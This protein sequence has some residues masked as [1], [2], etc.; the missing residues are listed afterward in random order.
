MTERT[1][2]HP[3][4]GRL[5]SLRDRG[6]RSGRA[7][8]LRSVR[9]ALVS[10]AGLIGRPVSNQAGDEV[11]RVVDVVVNFSPDTELE[12]Y[13]PATGLIIRVGR[14]RSWVP[15]SQIAHVA[16]GEV[17]LASARVDLREF[18]PRDGEMQ[19]AASVLDHQLIDV[20]GRRVIRAADLVL[21]QLRGE[22]RLVG[23][24]VST[25]SLLRRLGPARL[26]VRPTPERVIDWAAIQPLAD[27]DRIGGVRLRTSGRA[28]SALRPGELAD[29]LEE[30]GRSERQHLL[31][32]LDPEAAADAV[33][34]MHDDDVHRLLRD[35]PPETAA[36]LL[37]QMEPDEA[38]DAL[39][40]M[41]A[42]ERAR[43]LDAMP[44]DVS[45]RLARLLGYDE[46]RAGGV[47]T[48]TL[49]QCAEHDTVAQVTERLRDLAAHAVDLSAIVVVDPQ[50]RLLDDV[51]VL[52]L[53][54]ADRDRRLSELIGPPWPVTV[55]PDTPVSEVAVALIA[56]RSASILVV[57]EDGRPLGRI[58]A[59]DIVDAL[60]SDKTRFQLFRHAPA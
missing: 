14:R 50:G 31:D 27:A 16:H 9:E 39:R 35:A 56:N 54:L 36:E 32:T 42:A 21:A 18:E 19:L 8:A 25:T 58:L 30:L 10:L 55:S 6:L 57:D 12:P 20:D 15:A 44:T 23:V 38:V 60:V 7:L 3:R 47:M 28:L 4:W 1:Y 37:A 5:R 40:D 17:R 11:G 43:L 48:S 52:E 59:D 13:P 45:A 22:L 34:E 33:E 51:T 46:D 53:L 2:A 41:T 26:R 29:L 49:V 24:D